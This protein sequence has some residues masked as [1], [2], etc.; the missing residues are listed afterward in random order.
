MYSDRLTMNLLKI[1]SVIP[2]FSLCVL[3][4]QYTNRQMFENEIDKIQVENEVRLSHH[5]ISDLSWEELNAAQ[6]WLLLTIFLMFSFHV[7]RYMK[8][9]LHHIS[10][11]CGHHHFEFDHSLPN[12]FDSL[13]KYDVEDF[14]DD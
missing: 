2:M 1:M 3:F 5:N 7:G 10:H 11:N 14:L 8:G 13:K 4:W 12:F 9:F 6:R